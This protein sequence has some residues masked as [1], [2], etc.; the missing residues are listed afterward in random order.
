MSPISE[1]SAVPA[2]PA[3][4]SAVMTGPSSLMSASALAS[5]SAEVEPKRCSRSNSCRP[6][7]MPR[8]RPLSITITTEREPV[9]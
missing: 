4:N 2:R 7:T 6:S 1:A 3:N 5:P 9:L 8:N